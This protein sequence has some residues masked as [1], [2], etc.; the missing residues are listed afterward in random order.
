M[1]H[2]LKGETILRSGLYCLLQ[3]SIALLCWGPATQPLAS[4]G[5]ALGAT[6]QR[7]RILRQALERS[8]FSLR[9]APVK[10]GADA[11]SR[12]ASGGAQVSTLCDSGVMARPA[13]A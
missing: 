6:L 10:N 11:T 8:G 13:A 3:L 5:G 7:D 2:V 9:M 12:L 1:A 4:P